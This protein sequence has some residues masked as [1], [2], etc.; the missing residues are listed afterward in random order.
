MVSVKGETSLPTQALILRLLRENPEETWTIPQVTRA[1]RHRKNPVKIALSRLATAGKVVRIDRGLYQHPAG[2]V[3]RGVPDPRLRIH[4]LKVECRCN[5][6]MGWPF[7]RVSRMVTER[8][9]SPTMGR[10]P[11][12]KAIFTHTDWDGRPVTIQV[13]PDKTV[14][15]EVFLATSERPLHLLEVHGFLT[16]WLLGAFGI[17]QEFWT[18]KQADWNIDV[19]GTIKSDLGVVGLSVAS[20]TKVILKVYQ[21][22]E[23]LVRTEVR[24][25]QPLSAQRLAD[26][27]RDIL[28]SLEDVAS[29]RKRGTDGGPRDTM[30]Q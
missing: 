30:G 22:S 21:K 17:P 29:N 11:K 26:Y 19:R 27:L 9:P 8:F 3:R 12:N 13:H 18:V 10:H 4:A 5:Q 7:R 20:F 23:D 25:F 16:A 15:L 24:S 2:L 14:L 6:T 28:L 1:I